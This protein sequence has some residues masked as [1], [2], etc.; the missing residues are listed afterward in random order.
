MSVQRLSFYRAIVLAVDGDDDGAVASLVTAVQ[1]RRPLQGYAY[2]LLPAADA[3]HV[4]ERTNASG[5]ALSRLGAALDGL[6]D[7]Q[8][9]SKWFQELRRTDL[10]N[11]RGFYGAPYL[12]QLAFATALFL[13]RPWATHMLNSQLR[14][15]ADLVA[16]AKYPWPDRIDR[17]IAVGSGDIF[18]SNVPGSASAARAQRP[19]EG[20]VLGSASTTAAFRSLRTAIAV[21]QYRREHA[22]RLPASLAELVPADIQSI[23]VD[24]FSGNA[25]L[26]KA[27]GDTYSVYSVGSNRRDDGGKDMNIPYVAFPTQPLADIGVRMRYH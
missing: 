1:L 22:R 17:T 21:E 11:P 26:M 8:A 7:D 20:L 25:L 19:L 5:A 4:L 6:D 18:P 12:G 15:F 9:L 23:P 24:P 13:E 27:D 14:T 3:A 16:A 10:G 2:N